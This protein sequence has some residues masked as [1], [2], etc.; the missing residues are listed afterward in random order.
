MIVR[1][2]LTRFLGETEA[3]D[4]LPEE[5]TG[6]WK[7][8]LVNGVR[9]LVETEIAARSEYDGPPIDILRLD[10]NGAQW[11]QKKPECLGP[12]PPKR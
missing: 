10:K 2:R 3:I 7:E 8:G 6:F 5:T 4:G 11:I 9:R 1:A 12:T